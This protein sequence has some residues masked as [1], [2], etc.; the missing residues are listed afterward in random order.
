CSGK[1]WSGPARQGTYVTRLVIGE[2]LG[3]A[4]LGSTGHTEVN[5]RC[6]SIRNPKVSLDSVLPPFFLT[7]TFLFD[8]RCTSIGESES[9]YALRRYTLFAAK[10][11]LHSFGRET[12]DALNY[13]LSA[14]RYTLSAFIRRRQA[15][16]IVPACP[17]ALRK[18]SYK[19]RIGAKDSMV[20]SLLIQA[21]GRWEFVL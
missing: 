8:F 13:S 15:I 12:A 6:L 5:K 16:L 17:L 10:P 11:P 18:L 2:L 9:Y 20:V 4:Q 21:G 14:R 19:N 3:A 7:S 1:E